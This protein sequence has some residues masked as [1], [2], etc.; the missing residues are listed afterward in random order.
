MSRNERV[1][2]RTARVFGA[3]MA[4][5]FVVGS[6]APLFAGEQLTLS[7]ST[8][9]VGGK[10][11]PKHV[12]AV[13]VVDQDGKLVKTLAVQGR[14]RAKHLSEW[15]AAADGG[16]FDGVSG[17]TRK[18]HNPFSVTWDLRDSRGKEV[19]A[20]HYRILLEMTD[21]NSKKNKFHRSSLSFEKDGKARRQ[22]V[23]AKDGFENIEL[24]YVVGAG[25]ER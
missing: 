10:Y 12:L 25:G 6:G 23:G 17:A 5:F 21:D 9:S 11:A 20:G 18:A 16:K 22:Q 13:W 8:T 19:A 1:L 15:R 3:V 4:L 24:E 2:R 7:F 14:K